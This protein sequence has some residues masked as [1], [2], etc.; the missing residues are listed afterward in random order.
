MNKIDCFMREYRFLSNF[1]ASTVLLDGVEYPTV[2]N[3]YQAAKTLDLP[4]REPFTRISARDAKRLGKTLLL[5]G[6]WEKVKYAY[7]YDFVRQKFSTHP[8]L[9]RK[10]LNTGDAY[11]EEGNTW[12]D[13]YWGVCDGFGENNL[14]KILMEVRERL[15]NR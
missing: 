12:R 14:G 10:L 6:D 7:M 11:L 5:R 13:F 1:Q 3:A 2:E 8:S 9:Q 15:Q 4:L